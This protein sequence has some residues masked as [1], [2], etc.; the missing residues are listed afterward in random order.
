MNPK[1]MGERIK[2]L[3]LMAADPLLDLTK[4]ELSAMRAIVE[5][6]REGQEL[7]ERVT[8]EFDLDA[9]EVSLS[10]VEQRLYSKALT[11]SATVLDAPQAEAVGEVV[12]HAGNRTCPPCTSNC[13][14]GRTCA[15]QE[16][17][18][19]QL[20]PGV[21]WICLTAWIAVAAT[22]GMVWTIGTLA[23]LWQ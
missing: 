5:E 20:D 21:L 19:M 15:A 13:N 11:R 16:K 10:P 6:L 9:G 8:E 18:V 4:G 12:E 14:Q 22:V 23:G 7:I 2:R 1:D 3:D 17:P